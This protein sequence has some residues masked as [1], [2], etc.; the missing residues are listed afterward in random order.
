MRI[1]IAAAGHGASNW[2]SRFCTASAA[3]AAQGAATPESIF[4]TLEQ[5]TASIHEK[6]GEV[7]R[8]AFLV[9]L[10]CSQLL[11]HCLLRPDSLRGADLRAGLYLLPAVLLEA[12]TLKG[13]PSQCSTPLL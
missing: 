1:F 12:I 11:F 4:M 9:I 3:G 10:C 13:R 2:T 7:R 5:C 8:P 6:T